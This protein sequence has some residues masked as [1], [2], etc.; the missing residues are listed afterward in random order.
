V[1]A[2]LLAATAS[3]LWGA[4][5]FVGGVTAKRIPVLL[6][7]L[8]TWGAGLVLTI[9]IVLAFD[10]GLPPQ[11]TFVFGLVGGV[12]GAV[13]LGSLYQGLA[14]GRMGI[15]APIAALSVLVGV[16]VGFLQGDRP[17]DV[18]LVGMVA[19]VVG[20]VLA[21]TAPDPAGPRTGPVAGGV[22]YGVLAAVFLGGTLVCLDAA[23]EASA[24][25]SALLIRSSSVPL[26]ALV[27]LVTRPS[28]AALRRRDV[29]VLSAVGAADNGANVLFALATARGLLTL[30]AVIASLVPVVTVLL[31]RFVLH[32]HLTRHQL[33]GVALALGGVAA[34]AAG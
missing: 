16:L 28:V 30:V 18:Q 8:I 19:A 26:V 3:T 13:G 25:W 1:L 6:V 4:G 2:V 5:D 22:G 12:F 11:R 27:A 34:I 15:V 23:G 9:L 32:E 24:A 31:A 10:P 14:V 29:G 17:S 21:A 33:V 7:A 20:A